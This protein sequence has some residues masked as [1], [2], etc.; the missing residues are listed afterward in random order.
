MSSPFAIFRKN[1]K[2]MLA[3]VTLV[4]IL[5]FVFLPSANQ[6]QRGP[7]E[8]GGDPVAKTSVG[9]VTEG[10]LSN[11]RFQRIAA[12][13]IAFAAASKGDPQLAMRLQLVG[14]INNPQFT[15]QVMQEVEPFGPVRGPGSDRDLVASWLLSKEAERLGVRVTDAQINEFLIQRSAGKMQ[16]EDFKTAI[17]SQRMDEKAAFDVLRTQMEAKQVLNLLFPNDQMFSY[18]NYGPEQ[19]WEYYRRLHEQRKFELAELKVASFVN[20]VEDPKEA[21]IVALFEERKAKAPGFD[22]ETYQPGFRQPLRASMQYVA[23]QADEVRKQVLKDKPVTDAEVESYYKEHRAEFKIPKT[24]PNL[25]DAPDVPGA[26]AN[27]DTPLDP[28]FSKE[29]GAPKK[30]EDKPAPKPEDKPE[31]KPEDKPEAKPEDKPAPKPEDKPEAKPEDKPEAKPE[32]KPEAK[33]EGKPEAKP[34]GK[35]EAKPEDKPEAKPEEKK[36]DGTG[37]DDPPA[38]TEEKPAEAKPAEAKPAEQPAA[39]KPAESKPAAETPPEAKPADTKPA[40]AK[41]AEAKPAAGPEEPAK[42]GSAKMEGPA[43]GPVIIPDVFKPLDDEL[44]DVIRDRLKEQRFQDAIKAL[45][46]KTFNANNK[47]GKALTKKFDPLHIKPE[48]RAA[49]VEEAKQ[50]MQSHAKKPLTIYGETGLVSFTDFIKLPGIVTTSSLREE[51]LVKVFTNELLVSPGKWEDENGNRYVFWT[52]E[53]VEEHV[54]KLDDPGIREE[55]VKAWKLRE[56]VKLAEARAAELAKKAEAAK[57]PLADVLASETV[58]GDPKG[59]KISVI[60]TPLMTWVEQSAVPEMGNTM[61][62]SMSVSTK[63]I[64]MPQYE[65]MHQIFD[66]I[67]VGS[68]DVA[69]NPTMEGIT[70][71]VAKVVTSVPASQDAFLISEPFGPRADVAEV[72]RFDHQRVSS[73]FWRTLEEKYD[74]KW[75][76]QKRSSDD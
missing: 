71:Y 67:P 76:E 74:V 70:V 9:T 29:P 18:A 56:A 24:L 63:A 72:A 38:K 37:C 16:D 14:M 65:F 27:P 17:A 52:T 7:S 2:V 35:P 36:A 64:A 22:A 25:G 40:E 45:E 13:A 4:A 20:K 53:I 12:N 43:A 6:S 19:F 32:D 39:E 33:P 48:Q 11:L 15:A 10:E 68:A 75:E 61:Q 59:Q 3:G 50:A 46:T 30:P 28:E 47:L 23:L 58:T 49:L 31:A 41:P 1:S 55:V 60:T 26:P 8:S 73:R 57:K 54:P 42:Q 51:E 34:E 5:S 66:Q 21:D 62:R 69:L 44:K